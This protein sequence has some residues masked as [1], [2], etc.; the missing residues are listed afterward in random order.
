MS[1]NYL[2]KDWKELGWRSPSWQEQRELEKESTVSTE[3]SW[4]T[5]LRE[6]MQDEEDKIYQ[7]LCFNFFQH[8]SFG[9]T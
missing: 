1:E 8:F 3:A 2:E 7:K 6:D 5:Q 4:T 9:F